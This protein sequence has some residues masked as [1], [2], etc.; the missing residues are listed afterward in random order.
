MVVSSGFI[1]TFWLH[2]YLHLDVNFHYIYIDYN[3]DSDDGCV[4][5]EETAQSF[6]AWQTPVWKSSRDQ[7]WWGG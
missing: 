4:K 3:D 7:V 1:Y 5:W 6:E 2:L